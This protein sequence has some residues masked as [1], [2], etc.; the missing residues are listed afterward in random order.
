MSKKIKKQAIKTPNVL[1]CI[2]KKLTSILLLTLLAVAINTRAQD[3]IYKAISDAEKTVFTATTYNRGGG[4]IGKS[5]GFFIGSSGL[6]IVKGSIFIGADSIKIVDSR[7]LLLKVERV[8]AIHQPSDLAIVKIISD[9]KNNFNYLFPSSSIFTENEELLIFSQ[10]E[11]GEDGVQIERIA[12]IIE[13]PIYNRLGVLNSNMGANTFGSPA[14]NSK[15]ELVGI[16]GYLKAETPSFLYNCAILSDTNWVNLNIPIKK[17]KES[18]LKQAYLAP[19]LS[20]GLLSFAFEDWIGAAKNLTSHLT[21]F[22]NSAMGYAYRGYARYMY[23]NKDESKRDF[24]TARLLSATSLYTFYFEAL[25]A[26]QEGKKEKAYKLIDSSVYYQ[27]RFPQA[28]VLRGNLTLETNRPPNDALIDYSYAVQ[29]NDTYSEGYYYRALY[30]K[31]QSKNL[32]LAYS[33]MAKCVILNPSLPN[34]Y[35]I[36]GEMDIERE[37]FFEA[38]KNMSRAVDKDPQNAEALFMRGIVN[39]HLG[40]KR[41]ACNDW[42][43]SSD[44]GNEKA[45]SYLLRYCRSEQMAKS[46]LE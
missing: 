38:Q 3:N 1:T 8:V 24:A 7:N 32:D 5:A 42:K 39:Y 35:I 26:L 34:V 20:K 25:I 18:I 2:R 9:R 45:L 46:A 31:K 4:V 16:T 13:K 23:N 14:I 29:V 12:K 33:D 41:D 22:N 19:H 30:L 6:A 36:K 28:R 43:K 40:L 44:L 10:P 15:G 11:L 27:F 37:N 21:V 17:L